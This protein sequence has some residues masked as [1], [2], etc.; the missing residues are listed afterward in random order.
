MIG[1]QRDHPTEQMHPPGCMSTTATRFA[2]S[3]QD[4]ATGAHWSPASIA[5]TAFTKSRGEE[6]CRSVLWKRPDLSKRPAIRSHRGSNLFGEQTRW[7][8]SK[9][10]G[11]GF[12]ASGSTSHF[13]WNCFTIILKVFRKFSYV[14]I[15]FGKAL[16]PY[17]HPEATRSWQSGQLSWQR[18][19]YRKQRVH[20][21][22]II[23]G[24]SR[25]SGIAG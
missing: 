17:S 2:I 8:V 15:Y 10:S 16:S 21:Q 7:F 20:C 18:P 1:M 22:L 5:A 24:K 13:V 25:R 19:Q 6:M 14:R 4:R 23:V 9:Q 3:I 11:V 12:A